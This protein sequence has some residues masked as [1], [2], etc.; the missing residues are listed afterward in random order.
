MKPITADSSEGRVLLA[1]RAGPMSSGE[2][3]ER[4][5]GSGTTFAQ[6]LKRLGLVV[7]SDDEW[8][9]TPAGLAACPFRNPLAARAAGS[10]EVQIMPQGETKITREAVLDAI[11]EAGPAGISRKQLIEQFGAGESVIDNHIMHL[12]R[13]QPPVI[14]KPRP[15]FFVSTDHQA[16]ACA[17]DWIP[18]PLAT[19][20]PA[21]V[22][23]ALPAV[24]IEGVSLA[25]DH[26]DVGAMSPE[27][28]AA[29]MAQ[30]APPR[31]A[32]AFQG[33]FYDSIDAAVENAN[34]SY[35]S[36]S[37]AHAVVVQC[38]P[39]GRIEVRPVFVPAEAL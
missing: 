19:D 9:I 15:G 39:L 24:D 11:E 23:S 27:A 28:E 1:L 22:G 8:R 16:A 18:E 20:P 10:M 29:Q 17:G 6:T 13:Q 38:T 21:N 37:L 36:D 5:P 34:R 25:V 33:D 14:V 35:D 26:H 2:M 31:Y 4:W 12:N 32:V 3:W 30:I 7:F